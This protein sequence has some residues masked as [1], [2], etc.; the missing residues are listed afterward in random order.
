MAWTTTQLLAEIR[1]V[2][3]VPVTSTQTGYADA[4][5]LVHADA[6]LQGIVAPLVANARDEHAVHTVDVAVASGQATAR[7]P[8][9]VGAGRLRDVT[10]LSSD[11]Q[12]YVNVP[13]F[14]PEDV[15]GIRSGSGV[16][17]TAISIVVQGGFLRI[18]PA[19]TDALTLRISYVRTP[20]PFALVST[21][22]AATGITIGAQLL[23]GHAGTLTAGNY[24]IILVSNGD[25]LGDSVATI[26]PVLGSTTFANSQLSPMFA[27]V[28]AEATRYLAEGFYL[29]PAGTSCVVPLPDM[30]SSLLAYHAAAN[31]MHSIGDVD[32]AT[33]AERTADRMRE[34]LLPLLS[35][36]IEGEP[37]TVVPQLH[38]RGRNWRW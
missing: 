17:P 31:L 13:R 28:Q 36:R 29:C 33:R 16:A 8:P 15:A 22:T 38:R 35:E 37:Q 2:S 7:L 5:L 11:G 18:F 30:A 21:C 1:R 4:D 20:S 25:S 34:Q 26:A 32:A 10:M 3:F 27:Q 19:P 9:R 24:D 12:A 14:E 23:V 6:A